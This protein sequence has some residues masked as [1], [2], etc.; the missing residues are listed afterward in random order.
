MGEIKIYK[1]EKDLYE[2]TLTA[3][4]TGL[5]AYPHINFSDLKITS[6]VQSAYKVADAVIEEK[7]SR[8]ARS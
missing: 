2:K 6:Y 7:R 1:E 5:L 4:I 3:A 8:K